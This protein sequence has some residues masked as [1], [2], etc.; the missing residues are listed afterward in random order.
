[1]NY[2]IKAQIAHIIAITKTFEQS[3]EMAAKQDDGTISK[4]EEKALKKIKAAT[5]HFIKDLEKI[6]KEP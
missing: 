2:Y 6:S 1:M 4:S 3:C 5:N